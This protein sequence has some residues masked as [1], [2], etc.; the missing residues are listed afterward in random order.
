MSEVKLGNVLGLLAI[1]GA[2]GV[3]TLGWGI[4]GR[5]DQGSSP[6]QSQAPSTVPGCA[7]AATSPLVTPNA[8][9]ADAVMPSRWRY[10]RSTDDMR[11]TETRTAC[12]TASDRLMFQ[13]PYQ[14]GSSAELCLRQRGRAFDAFISVSRGQ[15]ICHLRDCPI[16]LKVD[17]GAVIELGGDPPDSA[18]HDI[19]FLRRGS[20]LRQK[21]LRARRFIVEATF[22]R[23][24]ARQIVF[25]GAQGLVWPPPTGR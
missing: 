5:G 15:F 21:L 24:G 7:P 25:E 17:E 18:A 12:I 1:A 9:T 22:Y 13:F 19:V 10:D 3:C 8:A 4:S 23:E 20:T 2:C 14:G 16:A 11:G 6:Q